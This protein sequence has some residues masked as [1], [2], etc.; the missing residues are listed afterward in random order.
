M[1]G[2]PNVLT[3]ASSPRGRLPVEVAARRPE[4]PVFRLPFRELDEVLAA[5]TL[6]VPPGIERRRTGR[7]P[8]L[9]VGPSVPGSGS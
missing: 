5:A 2:T 1:P 8:S 4:Q 6:G 9:P 7:S 3:Q